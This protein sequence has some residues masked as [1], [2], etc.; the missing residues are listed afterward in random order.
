MQVE[1]DV[2]LKMLIEPMSSSIV[3]PNIKKKSSGSLF[4]ELLDKPSKT[5]VIREYLYQGAAVSLA[6]G[7][8]LRGVMTH[9]KKHGFLQSPLRF[10]SHISSMDVCRFPPDFVNIMV[11]KEV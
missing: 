11:P 4:D 2:R 1:G 9:Y 5:R 8:R 6:N 7:T 3:Q 10:G